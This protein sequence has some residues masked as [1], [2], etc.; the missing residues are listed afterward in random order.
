MENTI[1]STTS[2]NSGKETNLH[3]GDEADIE[4]TCYADHR[5]I[6]TGRVSRRGSKRL[7]QLSRHQDQ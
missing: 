6:N 5:E 7:L 4:E 2:G 3:H 1:T